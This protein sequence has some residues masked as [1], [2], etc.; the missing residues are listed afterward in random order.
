MKKY[1]I[2]VF[3][4]LILVFIGIRASKGFSK[5]ISIIPSPNYE[6]VF[7]TNG[8]TFFGDMQNGF[9]LNAVAI[10]TDASGTPQVVK[11]GGLYGGEDQLW[12]N[13]STI[14]YTEPLSSNSQL[15]QLIK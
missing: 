8:Q 2:L 1:V 15:L 12:L 3:I 10:Q 11:I 5:P 13:P 6:A 9:L 7:L 14:S 4:V